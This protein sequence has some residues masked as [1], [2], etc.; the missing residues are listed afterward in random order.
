[1]QG[2]KP[3]VRLLTLLEFPEPLVNQ[4]VGV[5]ILE[6]GAMLRW[7]DVHPSGTQEQW[8]NV[9]DDFLNSLCEWN[10]ARFWQQFSDKDPGKFAVVS[11]LPSTNILR[12]FSL[13]LNQ[14][15]AQF[16][17]KPAEGLDHEPVGEAA[18]LFVCAAATSYHLSQ[19]RQR[20]DAMQGVEGLCM[21]KKWI[22]SGAWLTNFFWNY[23][24]DLQGPGL[25]HRKDNGLM[26][27]S[28]PEAMQLY[29]G[30]V[31]TK[32]NQHLQLKR[33]MKPVMSLLAHKHQAQFDLGI[34][35]DCTLSQAVEHYVRTIPKLKTSTSAW[36]HCVKGGCIHAKWFQLHAYGGEHS[37]QIYTTP[38][39]DVTRILYTDS[40]RNGEHSSR[41]CEFSPAKLPDFL[42]YLVSPRDEGT[43]PGKCFYIVVY[44]PMIKGSV[45]PADLSM[46]TIHN[47]LGNQP[48]IR[49]NMKCG[50]TWKLL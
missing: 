45:T 7:F 35:K 18:C 4:C 13:N 38:D 5:A 2:A 37:S 8:C 10:G 50:I 12:L 21:L 14:D 41:H 44:I 11:E 47:Q 34:D 33:L 23:K 49:S 39:L 22:A 48:R 42:K 24:M 26:L 40:H 9:D 36:C 31:T 17:A 1:M 28:P 46:E 27:T 19:K 30:L 20:F 43:S 32:G 16:R 3:D 25:E 15:N 29:Q 6:Y